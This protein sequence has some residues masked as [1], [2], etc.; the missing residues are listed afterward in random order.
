[1]IELDCI[2]LHF[3]PFEFVPRYCDPQLQMGENNLYTYII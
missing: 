2:I 3:H 1:M